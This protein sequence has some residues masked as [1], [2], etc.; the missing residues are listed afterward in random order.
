MSL[1]SSINSQ[2]TEIWYG[3][4]NFVNNTLECIS[5]IKERLDICGDSLNPCVTISFDSIREAYIGLKKKGCKDTVCYR[6]Y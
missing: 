6:D 4:E 2:K 3:L 5:I 1:S